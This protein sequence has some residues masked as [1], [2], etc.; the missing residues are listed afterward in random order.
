MS[1]ATV[2]GERRRA[3]R[4]A[5]S[6]SV[7]KVERKNGVGGS[8][9]VTADLVDTSED[10]IGICLKVPLP[11]GSTV[12]LR[13]KVGKDDKNARLRAI[14][15]WCREEANGTFRVGLLVLEREPDA[16]P[17]GR[18]STRPV[19]DETDYYEVMEL[20]PNAEAET[21][22][23]VYRILA[24]RYHPDSAVTG[25]SDMFVQVCEAY[26]VLS[27]P[28]K[29]AQYDARHR[30]RRQLEWRIFDQTETT[31]G[32]DI[33]RRKRD[34]ILGLLYAKLTHD[35][36]HPVMTIFEFERLLGCA[37]EHLQA[38]LWYLKGKGQIQRS[39]NASF[40]ITVQG[41]DE[42]EARC[43]PRRTAELPLLRPSS[44]A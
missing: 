19:S 41:V 33:E 24:Q 25:N 32:P 5:S 20:S 1:T 3:R 39:D 36:E 42:F 8:S 15:R 28:E 27:D 14:V 7:I 34:G 9:W 12:D 17:G 30:E 38:A 13:G 44:P 29:R 43:P 6:P 31:K 16:D 40:S 26:R 37:R 4:A 2:R 18:T 10:G 35:P 23:R 22:A 11:A 21:I